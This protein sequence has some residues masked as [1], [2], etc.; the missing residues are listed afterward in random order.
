MTLGHCKTD[1]FHIKLF[2]EYFLMFSTKL[3]DFHKHLLKFQSGKCKMEQ[4]DDPVYGWF[5]FK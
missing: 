1:L 3:V 2:F 4:T 5:R